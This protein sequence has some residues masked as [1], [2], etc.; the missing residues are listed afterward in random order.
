MN[1]ASRGKHIV[2]HHLTIVTR[3]IVELRK[4]EIQEPTIIDGSTVGVVDGGGG[5]ESMV[6]ITC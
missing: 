2:A 3:L 1:W 6:I 5:Q 4:E